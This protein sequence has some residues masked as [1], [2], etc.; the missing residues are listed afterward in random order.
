MSLS[1]SCDWEAEPGS[2]C[3]DYDGSSQDFEPLKTSKRKRCCS[4]KKLIDIGSLC[5]IHPRYRYPHNEIEARITGCDW[6]LN[7]EPTIKISDHYQCEK[8]A[9]IWLNLTDLGY[10][11][12]WPGEDMKKSLKEYHEITGFNKSEQL[13]PGI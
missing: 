7:E 2:I 13:L 11:C 10:E 1:C 9:E 5:I 8:C 4:C 6:D 3:Y 12:L